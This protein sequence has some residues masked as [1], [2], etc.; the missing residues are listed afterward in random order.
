MDWGFAGQVSVVVLSAAVIGW[1]V[2]ASYATRKEDERRESLRYTAN[3]ETDRQ[4]FR[5]RTPETIT[6]H[7]ERA[8]MNRT[9]ET[10]IT[11]GIERAQKDETEKA[12]AG[13]PRLS[14]NR[15]L[16]IARPGTR[17]IRA[18]EDK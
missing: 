6:Q 17:N 10:A 12:A 13:R 11:P 8:R 7:I 4:V 16:S 5:N 2:L 3:A 14:T 9:T 18:A 15:S 1:I